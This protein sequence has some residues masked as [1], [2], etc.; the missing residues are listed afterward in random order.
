MA[1][2]LYSARE[3]KIISFFWTS[4]RSRLLELLLCLLLTV[5]EHVVPAL[6]FTIG[7]VEA[8]PRP[9]LHNPRR[10][11]FTAMPAG[12]DGER[13]SHLGTGLERRSKTIHV[14]PAWVLCPAH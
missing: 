14:E 9:R 11:N 2:S 5:R 7:D 12:A 6:N 8:T 4:V 1:I 10:Q 13:E 3:P